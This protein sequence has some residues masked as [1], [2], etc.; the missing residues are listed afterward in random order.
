[1]YTA[2]NARIKRLAVVTWHILTDACGIPWQ[3]RTCQAQGDVILPPTPLPVIVCGVILLLS[4]SDAL[5]E[6]IG[7][8]HYPM[9]HSALRTEFN[10]TRIIPVRWRTINI[11]KLVSIYK[12]TVDKGGFG[13]FILLCVLA[14]LLLRLTVHRGLVGLW[15]PAEQN[16]FIPEV[17]KEK[18]SNQTISAIV[19]GTKT[20]TW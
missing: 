15:L 19:T 4:N 2:N 12:I 17:R 1:M 7:T 9:E 8:A 18:T 5:R 11:A 6:R 10:C 16:S 14:F 20:F 13:L 3:K